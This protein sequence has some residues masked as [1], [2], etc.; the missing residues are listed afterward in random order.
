MSS[1]SW[2]QKTL[3]ISLFFLALKEKQRKTKSGINHIAVGGTANYHLI[4]SPP[5]ID[6]QLLKIPHVPLLLSGTKNLS[7]CLIICKK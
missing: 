2:F 4:Q 5:V 3:Y 1:V 7:S 6:P